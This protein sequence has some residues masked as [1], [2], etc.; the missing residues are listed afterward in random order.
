MNKRKRYHE[1]FP[2]AQFTFKQLD[3]HIKEMEAFIEEYE[4]KIQISDW[5]RG[6]LNKH[7]VS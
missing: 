5:Y 4:N 7:I 1:K 2:L 6:E 3:S